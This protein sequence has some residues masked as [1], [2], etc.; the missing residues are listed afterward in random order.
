MTLEAYEKQL[1]EKRKALEA[2]KQEE[3]K[4]RLDKD[5]ELKQLIGRKKEDFATKLVSYFLMIRHIL[6]QPKLQNISSS[7]PYISNRDFFFL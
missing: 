1:I 3:R 6:L 7:C 2:L 4:V 5:F